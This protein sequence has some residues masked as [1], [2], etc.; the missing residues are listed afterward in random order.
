M[1]N[2]ETIDQIDDYHDKLVR[3]YEEFRKKHPAYQAWK[4]ALPNGGKAIGINPADAP[5]APTLASADVE[6]AKVNEDNE[7]EELSITKTKCGRAFCNWFIAVMFI[8]FMS[9]LIYASYLWPPV[10]IIM[11]SA[12]L[13]CYVCERCFECMHRDKLKKIDMSG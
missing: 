3:E 2:F 8:F 4:L 9:I 1:E 7:D 10:L 13:T 5:A 11:V 6:A 12:I